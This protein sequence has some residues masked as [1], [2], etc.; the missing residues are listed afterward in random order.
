MSG[1]FS[2]RVHQKHKGA[3]GGLHGHAGPI[4]YIDSS[5]AFEKCRVGHFQYH[6]QRFYHTSLSFDFRRPFFTTVCR[7]RR[8]QPL[9]AMI[10]Y[11]CLALELFFSPHAAVRLW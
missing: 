1:T 3:T 2:R 10:A 4:I 9:L 6:A 8:R 5:R 7:N 11:R